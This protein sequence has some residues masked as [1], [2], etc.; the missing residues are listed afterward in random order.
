MEDI[1]TVLQNIRER[2]FPSEE[3]SRN[4]LEVAQA[5]KEAVEKAVRESGAEG[6]DTILVGS[7]AKGTYLKDP[8]VDVFLRFPG[9][10][11]FPTL[12]KKGLEI[13]K[14]VLPDGVEK[15]AQHP[16]IMGEFQGLEM[17]IVPCIKIEEGEDVISAV[18]RTP[19]HC[20][21]ILENL[22]EKNYDDVRFLKAFTK[23]IG[24]YGANEEFQGLSGYLCELLVVHYGGFK[25]VLKASTEWKE[26]TRIKI[27]GTEDAGLDH[28]SYLTFIDPTDPKRNVAQALSNE[29]AELFKTACKAFLAGPDTRFFYPNTPSPATVEEYNEYLKDFGVLSITMEHQPDM[30]RDHVFGQARK[31]KNS[32]EKVFE[33]NDIPVAKSRFYIENDIHIIISWKRGAFDREVLHKGPPVQAEE[34]VMKFQEKWKGSKEALGNT[35]EKDGFIWVKRYPLYRDPIVL[36]NSSLSSIAWGK[37]LKLLLKGIVMI[38]DEEIHTIDDGSMISDFIRGKYPWEY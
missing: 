2:K 7:V 11:L 34:H 28:K 13:G 36:I 27:K 10:T 23:G 30:L 25:E 15:Y 9:N 19:L 8:D 5:A 18:D 33:R 17:D 21:F 32:I 38:R 12:E 3:E 16:Y 14:L 26:G 35:F 1:D 31:T 6:V 37:D 29:S 4:I 22:S 20:K 24:V